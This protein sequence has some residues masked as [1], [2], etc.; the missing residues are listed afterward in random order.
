M[1]YSIGFIM[2]ILLIF[3]AVGFV[4][5]HADTSDVCTSG[6][7]YKSIQS[8]IDAA[9]PNNTIKVST[10][11]YVENL[12]INKSIIIKG[13]GLGKTI[14]D[15]PRE[16]NLYGSTVT[17]GPNIGVTLSGLNI[18]GG[19]GTILD[20]KYGGGIL[21][22]G[23]LALRDC[24]ISNNTADYG[25]GIYNRNGAILSLHNCFIHNNIALD[26]GGI[27][28]SEGGTIDID[29]GMITNNSADGGGIFNLGTLNLNSGYIINNRGQDGGGIYNFVSGILNLNGGYVS[30]NSVNQRNGNGGGIFNNDG[31]I[32]MNNGNVT[33]NTA[34]WGGGV[35][36]YGTM[37]QSGGSIDHNTAYLGGGIY[38]L[39]LADDLLYHTIEERMLT[40]KGGSISYNTAV[41]DNNSGVPDTGSGGGVYADLA[42]AITLDGGHIF[43]N[44]A[45]VG[46]GICINQRALTI[47]SGSVDHN[48]ATYGGGVF[49]S[50]PMTQTGGSISYNTATIDGGG[51][52]L[53]GV[54][55]LKRHILARGS[56]NLKDGS[57]DNNTAPIGGGIFND[58]SMISGNTVL[59]KNNKPY[60]IESS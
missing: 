33:G 38:Q 1:R 32:N 40:L 45:S 59:V 46:G 27:Y 9:S 30:N 26:G 18:Q 37:I 20:A 15:R 13:A 48:T 17:T 39:G 49:N 6:C 29:G 36:D 24:S 44:K 57:I 3:A 22:D 21:N 47:K 11:T 42:G 43:G 53:M 19:T 55:E 5:V 52:Y 58:R 34:I 51:I 2:L 4:F 50:G 12:Y 41:R 31:I 35:F 25:G 56:L 16:N 14:I 7:N 10:G 23:I 54:T 8:A 60:Q 28:N